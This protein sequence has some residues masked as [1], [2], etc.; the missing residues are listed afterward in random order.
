MPSEV[1]TCGRCGALALPEGSVTVVMVGVP[2]M[3][4]TATLLRCSGC[5]LRF[6]VLP[7]FMLALFGVAVAL[8]AWL[9]VIAPEV[10]PMFA[11]IGAVP[12]G[13]LIHQIYVRRSHRPAPAESAAV[14][15]RALGDERIQALLRQFTGP[16]APDR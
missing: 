15:G 16:R 2:P 4:G 13:L 5:G 11:V 3:A 14:L 8:M 6:R 7:T 9:M 1:R 10:W 12:F